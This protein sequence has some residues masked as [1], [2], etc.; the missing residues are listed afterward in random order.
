MIN[1]TFENIKTNKATG[2]VPY[3]V[4]HYPNRDTFKEALTLLA[5]LNADVIEIGIPFTDPI[6]EGKVIDN[7][8]ISDLL[9][10]VKDFKSKFD[11]PLI[12]MGYTNSFINPDQE[13]FCLKAKNAGFDGFLIVDMPYVEHEM[14][15][16]I[17]NNDLEF[18]QLLA[19]TSTDKTIINCLANEPAMVYYI[20][21]R[22]VTGSGNLDY[23]EITEN[24]K[25]LRDKINV[26]L[27]TGFGI[28]TT[29]HAKQFKNFTDG[30]VIGSSIVDILSKPNPITTL[31]NYISPIIKEIKA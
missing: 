6:A 30:I 26:P 10:D 23:A 17:K 24:L 19:P 13:S 29:E 2:F 1:K 8:N 22:G 16:I 11:T 12:A 31:E 3:I 14:I 21:Q 4:A 20:T 18:V 25:A 5:E 15:E 9:D 28:K 27:V 7:F